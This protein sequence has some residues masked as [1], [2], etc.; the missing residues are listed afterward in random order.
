MWIQISHLF[1]FVLNLW[2]IISHT[3]LLLFFSEY[4]VQTKLHL[5][6]IKNIPD[7]KLEFKNEIYLHGF[8]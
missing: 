8:L 4:G 6:N 7:R 1:A 3:G 2:K 5:S